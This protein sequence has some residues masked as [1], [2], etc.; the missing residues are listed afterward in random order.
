MVTQ[1]YKRIYE[2]TA[3]SFRVFDAR[4]GTCQAD[5]FGTP[6]EAYESVGFNSRDSYITEEWP[7]ERVVHPIYGEEENSDD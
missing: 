3:P 5:H 2:M 6:E 4:F 7:N 1:K